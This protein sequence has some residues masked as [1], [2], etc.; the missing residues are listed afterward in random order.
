M[1][2][3]RRLTAGAIAPFVLL[4]GCSSDD[5]SGP[6]PSESAAAK[7]SAQDKADQDESI[8]IG[9]AGDVLP[10]Y[11]VQRNAE[12]N[13]GG[14]GYDFAPMFAG[15][16]D[17]LSEPDATL[18]HME[19]P[20]SP[21][22]THLTEPKAMTFNSPSEIADALVDAGYDG[23]DT[24][25]N[26]LWDQTLDGVGDT[27]TA[28]EDA[29][30]EVAGPRG[31]EG[32]DRTATYDLDGVGVTQLAYTYTIHNDGSPTTTV[33]DEAPWLRD[34]LWPAVG[35]E[36]I[37]KDARAAKKDGADYVVVSM[38]WGQEYQT[39]PTDDQLTIAK[40]LLESD[41]VDLVLGT[42]AHVV[43]PCEK[44]NGKYVLY[45]LGNTLSN[46]SPETSDGLRPETQEG[47]IARV[48][49]SKGKNGKVSSSLRYQPTKVRMK[50]HAI[51]PATAKTSPETHDRVVRTMGSLGAGRCDAQPMK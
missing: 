17:V 14:S 40:K 16:K 39:E 4:A 28:L 19:T 13:A 22:D 27:R 26:H 10:H 7:G 5:G 32:G 18:C 37:L 42:H 41:S 23:C 9:A 43:Q 48:K 45:G 29:G 3:A 38:H 49:L 30:L 12:L 6:H 36:G 47:V 51:R 15:V 31:T 33:P 8:T 21:D 24:A 46:Q 1:G 34:S 2:I 11:P 25:S 50:D 44:I 35:A 20:V